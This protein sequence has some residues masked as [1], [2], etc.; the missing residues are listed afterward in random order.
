MR[1]RRLLL[2]VI[3][4]SLLVAYFDRVN[5]SVA[6][7]AMSKELHLSPLVF[8]AVLSAF[9]LGYAAMQIPAGALADRFGS[10]GVLTSAML[11]WSFFT[12][13]TAAA[14]SAAALLV[15]RLLFGLGEGLENGAQFKAIA[16]HFNSRERSFANGFFL[17][18]VAL[19]PAF[20][21]PLAVWALQ[22]V[23]WRGLFVL[24]VIP[25]VLVAALVWF[26][27]PHAQRAGALTESTPLQNASW[28]EALSSA[29]TWLVSVAYFGFNVALW[30]ML[31]W[32]PTYLSNER[33]L[34]ISALGWAAS[35]P[36][37]AG[38]VG[39][40]VIG[41][42]A[43]RAPVAARPAIIAACYALSAVGL[44]FAYAAPALA[45]CVLWLSV[46][47]FGMFGGFGPIW[48][49]AL[50]IAPTHARGAFSGFVNFTGQLAAIVS[51]FAVGAIVNVTHAFAGGFAFMIGGLLVAVA[52][53]L[54]LYVRGPRA[55]V[56]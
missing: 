38:F 19:G 15:V 46:A 51:P 25:G 43:M 13:L 33:G 34:H 16:D 24:C 23:G 54:V 7:P 35:L 53:M 4:L 41:W 45:D 48:A 44:Y 47:G 17:T 2:V 50:D 30:S 5:I 49:I 27:L 40:L 31:G 55:A 39:L 37:F 56:A 1:N 28:R 8:G 9:S 26:S 14:S 36:Y 10:R 20:I 32:L 42:V 52:S 12:G 22:A 3:W 11:L 6:G 29:P 21:V 18:A